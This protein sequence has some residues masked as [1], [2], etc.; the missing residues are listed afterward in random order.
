MV[1]GMINDL[2]IGSAVG[3]WEHKLCC[4][5]NVCELVCLGG[6]HRSRFAEAMSDQAAL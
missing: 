6:G 4:G 5:R 3:G 2:D 1:F